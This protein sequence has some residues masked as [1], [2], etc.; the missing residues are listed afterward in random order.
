MPVTMETKFRLG[1]M[2][3]MFTA[4]ATLQLVSAGKLSLD[5]SVGQYLPDYPNTE[6]AK[7]HHSPSCSTHAGGTGAFYLRTGFRQAS[8]GTEDATTTCA[9]TA[10]GPTHP[11]GE[12]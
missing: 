6:I 4:V 3:K 2:N 5:G 1:S 10:R 11:P 8:D 7:G 9:C 12:G